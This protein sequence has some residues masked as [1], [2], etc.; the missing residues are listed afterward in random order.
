M[1]TIIRHFTDSETMA[2]HAAEYVHNTAT[3]AVRR[4]GYFT[5]VLSGG[6][7]PRKLYEAFV[8]P[9]TNRHMPWDVTHIFWGD[10]RFV[11]PEHP[12]SNFHMAS[13]AFL[14][15]VPIPSANVHPVPVEMSSPQDAARA[16]ECEIDSFFRS[17]DTDYSGIPSF[18]LI[19]LG[20]GADGHTASLF[21]GAGADGEKNHMVVATEAPVES[22]VRQRVSLTLPVICNAAHVLFLVSGAEKKD[23]VKRILG[24]YEGAEVLPAAKVKAREELVWYTDYG[25]IAG[26][27]IFNR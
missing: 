23:L 3:A 11:P 15:R 24:L 20:V 17:C 7:T 27:D 5:L 13:D 22:P 19:L 12:G 18:D 8:R 25:S 9:A 2:R 1:K 26:D 10:E 6:S 4:R 16:Y 14:A 21:P